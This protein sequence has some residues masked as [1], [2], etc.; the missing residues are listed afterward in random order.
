M[1]TTILLI[2]IFLNIALGT[3]PLAGPVISGIF[4]GLLVGTRDL[5]MAIAF[6]GA[7]IGGALC[8]VFLNY[9]GNTWHHYLL[10]LFGKTAA[11]YTEL[12]IRGNLFFLALYFGLTGVLGTFIGAFLKN[13]I[14]KN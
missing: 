4:T 12:V 5:A 13:K 2:T 1:V 8:R 11:H 10:N 6:W 14:K 3:I 9:A 7:I